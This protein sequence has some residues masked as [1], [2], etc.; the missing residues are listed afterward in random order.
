MAKSW[1]IGCLPLVVFLAFKRIPLSVY[2]F[3][4]GRLPSVIG[5]NFWLNSNQYPILF[6]S[7]LSHPKPI[8]SKPRPIAA[9][10]TGHLNVSEAHFGPRALAIGHLVLNILI[11]TYS[12]VYATYLHYLF[13]L[14]LYLHKF[15]LVFKKPISYGLKMTIIWMYFAEKN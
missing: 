13:S 11:N 9:L 8:P 6:H 14:F 4:F 15:F 12:F 3:T 10:H 1:A 5:S 2:P 7:Y